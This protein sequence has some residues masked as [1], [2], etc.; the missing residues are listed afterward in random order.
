MGALIKGA[1]LA[2]MILNVSDYYL[3]LV[4][5]GGNA[6]TQLG[7]LLIGAVVLAELHD[8]FHK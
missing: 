5:M 7:T 2:D 8:I 6:T 1:L 3:G 4:P